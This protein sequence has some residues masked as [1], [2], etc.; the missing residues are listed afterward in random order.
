MSECLEQ[1]PTGSD[2]ELAAFMAE[3]ARGY[4][5]L[6]AELEACGCPICQEALR[7]LK[8]AGQ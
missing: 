3:E 6:E 7:K 8:G 2:L 4:P 5:V 1:L